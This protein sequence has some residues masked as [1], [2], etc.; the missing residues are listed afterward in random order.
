ML[1]IDMQ[2]LLDDEKL[3]FL[4]WC[5]SGLTAWQIW[6]SLSVCETGGWMHFSL[7]WSCSVHISYHFMN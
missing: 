1:S 2:F 3:Q 7:S 5:P 6:Q 4:I